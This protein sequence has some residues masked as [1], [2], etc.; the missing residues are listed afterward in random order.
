MKNQLNRFG[1]I[2]VAK[3]NIVYSMPVNRFKSEDRETIEELYKKKLSQLDYNEYFAFANSITELRAHF[4]FSYELRDCV[5]FLSI[6]NLK[7]EE[8]VPLLKTLVQIAKI[9]EETNTKV[10]WDINNFYINLSERYIQALLFEFEGMEI[11]SHKSA[12]DGLKEFIILSVTTLNHVI[13]KKPSKIDFIEKRDEVYQ[14]IED[15]LK[16]KEIE[17]VEA[18]IENALTFIEIA[19]E[20]EYNEKM[21]KKKKTLIGKLSLSKNTEKVQSASLSDRMKKEL[22]EESQKAGSK[23]YKEKKSLMDKLTSPVGIAVL[24]PVVLV[25]MVGY[26]VTDG[27]TDFGSEDKTAYAKEKNELKVKDIYIDYL[28]G[29][30][31][32][33]YSELDSIGYKNLSGDDQDMLI[34]WYI[35]QKKYVKAISLDK[36]SA[37]LI[38]DTFVKDKDKAG[39]E[40]LTNQVDSKVL[41]FD[42]AVLNKDYQGV[43]ANQ[44]LSELNK[45]RA[46]ELVKA[47]SLTNNEDDLEKFVTKFEKKDD[48]TEASQKQIEILQDAQST[49]STYAD[50]LKDIDK[51]IE[52]KKKEVQ[53]QEKKVKDKNN[54]DEKKEEELKTKQEEL[55]NLEQQREDT[56]KMVEEF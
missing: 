2:E 21:E 16:A 18:V 27:F 49:V 41:K 51:Q 37:Y 14:F 17:H 48:G 12:L 43:I 53:E 52:D 55:K 33:A 22:F 44:D 26:F 38:G 24:I 15:V 23:G 42:L 5:N 47:Y 11:F 13:V 9:A 32:K 8:V 19:A 4:M 50:S 35:E 29:D 28:N 34:K 7:F 56:I 25:V 1:E 31:E 45:R 54:K 6:R 36:D 40:Q 46:Y 10:L 30:K 3:N 39:L 20:R